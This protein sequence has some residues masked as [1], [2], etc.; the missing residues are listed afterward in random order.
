MRAVSTLWLYM[1][2]YLK[3]VWD[4][5]S[6][7]V[8]EQYETSLIQTG[9]K[10]DELQNELDKITWAS[11]LECCRIKYTTA[12]ENKEAFCRVIAAEKEAI[13]EAEGAKAV[14]RILDARQRTMPPCPDSSYDDLFDF[15]RSVGG[16]LDDDVDRFETMYEAVLEEWQIWDT[17]PSKHNAQL[18]PAKAID[19]SA[20]RTRLD[21][22]TTT[23][24]EGTSDRSPAVNSTPSADNSGRESPDSL[25]QSDDGSCD[26]SRDERR[27]RAIERLQ[28]TFNDSDTIGLEVLAGPLFS[29]TA[30]QY[31]EM[32]DGVYA[33][34]KTATCSI[35]QPE[36]VR[37]RSESPLAPSN[38]EEDCI[39]KSRRSSM[40]ASDRARRRGSVSFESGLVVD[41]VNP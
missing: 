31:F 21:A 39:T 35:A 17:L 37:S 5:T 32:I 18:P 29:T 15:L 38:A 26:Q 2:M 33:E 19:I 6:P 36:D 3:T 22:L 20:L 23:G 9:A 13:L 8:R 34:T 30:N 16:I 14:E 10:L 1:T 12:R 40:E 4:A 27:Q 7:S 28:E 24:V 11:L 25:A 41:P